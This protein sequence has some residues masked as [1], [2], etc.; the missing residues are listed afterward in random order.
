MAFPEK[1]EFLRTQQNLTQKAFVEKIGTSQSSINYWEKGQRIPSIKAAAKIADYLEVDSGHLSESRKSAI[2]R[3][4]FNR[5]F[6][7][8]RPIS[9]VS[10]IRIA[11]P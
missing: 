9:S 11:H 3:Y 10:S 4:A 2:L 7:P 6:F 5:A 1:L 8:R